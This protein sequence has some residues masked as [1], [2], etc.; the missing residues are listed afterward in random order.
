MTTDSAEPAFEDEAFEVLSVAA[1]M[2]NRAECERVEQ[3]HSEDGTSNS[4]LNWQ[5][6]IG[7]AIGQ[8]SRGRPSGAGRQDEEARIASS[9]RTG[10]DPSHSGQCMT[11]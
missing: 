9:A 10:K 3:R 8:R 7:T 11:Q 2:A 6:F 4:W 5:C 1:M